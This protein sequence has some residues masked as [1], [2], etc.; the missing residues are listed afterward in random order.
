M[1]K[2]RRILFAILLLAIFSALTWQAMRT[3]EPSYKGQP[4]SYWLQAYDPRFPISLSQ[5]QRNE[6]DAAVRR[7]GPKAIPTL[8]SMLKANDPPWKLKLNALLDKQHIFKI[9]HE[10]PIFQH[11]KAAHAFHVL[12][13]T[14]SPPCQL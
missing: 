3:R 10:E 13:L 4:L 9:K 6:I 8:L 7:M 2:A 5:A 14:P 1:G 12:A 11:V